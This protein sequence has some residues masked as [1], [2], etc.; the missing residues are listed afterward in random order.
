MGKFDSFLD[1]TVVVLIR[2]KYNFTLKNSSEVSLKKMLSRSYL[3]ESA[4]FRSNATVV[5]H[6]LSNVS[7]HSPLS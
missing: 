5:N 7:P 3:D 6:F 2:K 4:I 1:R